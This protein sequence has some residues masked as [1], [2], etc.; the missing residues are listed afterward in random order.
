MAKKYFFKVA[1]R[2]S[3]CVA[4]IRVIRALRMWLSNKGVSVMPTFMAIY[5]FK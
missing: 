1:D 4:W 2:R 3:Y 5:W